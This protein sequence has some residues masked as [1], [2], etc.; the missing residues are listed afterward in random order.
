MERV[1]VRRS[2]IAQPGRQPVLGG[3][4]ASTR[5]RKPTVN[6]EHRL[7][8]A[9]NTPPGEC[10]TALGRP[11][12][13]ASRG[14]W[15]TSEHTVVGGGALRWQTDP[16][17]REESGAATFALMSRRTRRLPRQGLMRWAKRRENRERH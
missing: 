5:A 14:G 8:D 3:V 2:E 17:Q 6:L 7:A 10:A 4:Q 16:D 1:Q 12:N 15:G 13:T 11:L 9:R